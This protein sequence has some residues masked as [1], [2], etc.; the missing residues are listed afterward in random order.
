[1]RFLRP[2]DAI[3]AVCYEMLLQIAPCEL[4]FMC[5]SIPSLT[6]P[7]RPP[8]P[9]PP[10][11]AN[12]KTFYERANSPPLALKKVPNP[13]PWGREIV[14]K[15]HPWAIFSKIQQRNA[16]H[17]KEILK[18]STQTLIC[19]EIFT[20]FGLRLLPAYKDWGGGGGGGGKMP[21]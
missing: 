8:P 3:S 13:D 12:P 20:L 14:L 21:S 2:H 9:P 1:M 15:L 4:A 6:I 17:E 7:P 18:N 16:K 11:L 19:I 10:S 5:Q